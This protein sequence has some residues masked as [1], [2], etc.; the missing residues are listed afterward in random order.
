M[1]MQFDG[2]L[3][4]ILGGI[5]VIICVMVAIWISA[6]LISMLITGIRERQDTKSK[7]KGCH[8]TTLSDHWKS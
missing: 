7:I 5:W 1:E 3:W 6:I 8:E 4:D 2:L